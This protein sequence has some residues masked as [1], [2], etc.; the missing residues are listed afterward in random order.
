M[1]ALMAFTT[2]IFDWDGTLL[3]TDQALLAP[4][5]ALGVAEEDVPWGNPLGEACA[6]L[7]ISMDEYLAAYDPALT[8]P[9]PGVHELV[10]GVVD[11]GLRW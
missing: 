4:F 1:P 8:V 9:W 10:A 7:G 6:A 3:D 2:V 11:R 5:V